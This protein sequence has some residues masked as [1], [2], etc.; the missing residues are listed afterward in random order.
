MDRGALVQSDVIQTLYYCI[1]KQRYT[2]AYRLAIALVAFQPN[3]PHFAIAHGLAAYHLEKHSE[4]MD[5]WIKCVR[6]A[7]T[8]KELVRLAFKNIQ[9]LEKSIVPVP[10]TVLTHK[11]PVLTWT[12]TTCK[13][14]ELFVRTVDSFLLKCLDLSLIHQF[15]VV[16]DYSSDE[17]RVRMVERYPF[18]DFVWKNHP[19]GEDKGHRHSMKILQGM[20]NTPFWL[21]LESDWEFQTPLDYCAMLMGVLNDPVAMKNKVAQCAMNCAY[22][23]NAEEF[24]KLNVPEKRELS[25]CGTRYYIHEHVNKKDEKGLSNSYW[26]HFTLQ[27]SMLLTAKINEIGLI[28]DTDKPHFERVYADVYAEKGYKTAYLDVLSCAHIGDEGP[29]AYALNGIAQF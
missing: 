9:F 17:D 3:D 15:I 7:N 12:M 28:G 27:P 14:Y 19:R 13:R 2:E 26:P 8:P 23:R 22:A 21:S 1:D 16:D 18:I 20:V 10:K 6:G 29:N 25:Q 11:L 5:A 24:G 4:A